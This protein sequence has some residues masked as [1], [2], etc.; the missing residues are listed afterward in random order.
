[1]SK[2]FSTAQYSYRMYK[3]ETLAIL[4]GLH[5]WEDKLL[6]RRFWII[7]NHQA[8]QFFSSQAQLSNCQIQWMEY[9]SRFHFEIT[10]VQGHK[11]VVV[12]ALSHY[13][14]SLPEN[15]VV[16]VDDWVKVDECL[17][18]DHDDLPMA[19]W[20]AVCVTKPVCQQEAIPVVEQPTKVGDPTIG[21]STWNSGSPREPL[22]ISLIGEKFTD[23]L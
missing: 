18:P 9:L 12:D 1:M 20:V 14:E 3:Q 11:N 10:Y 5:K 6:G 8:L 17:D 4:E 2:K 21:S 7:T 19:S 15:T 16:P 13:Y 23:L 22:H